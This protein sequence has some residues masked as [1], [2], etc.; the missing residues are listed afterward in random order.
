MCEN[1]SHLNDSSPGTPYDIVQGGRHYHPS[2]Q[3]CVDF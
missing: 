1:L 3:V 2:G